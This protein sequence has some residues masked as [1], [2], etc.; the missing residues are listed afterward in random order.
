MS[1]VRTARRIAA[2]RIGTAG[3]I[4][5]L[6]AACGSTSASDGSHG[7]TA[8]APSLPLATA[9]A[10]PGQ[11]GWAIV[12]MG[13]SSKDFEN[14][15]EL[16]ARPAGSPTWKLATPPGVASNGGL[17]MAAS[18]PGLVTGFR[19]SQDLTFSPLAAIASP[20]ATWS[21]GSAPVSPGLA[22]VPDALASGPHGAMIALTSTGQ[23]QLAAPGTATLARLTTE[24]ELARTAAGRACGLTA[25]TAVGFAADGTPLLAGT[26]TRGGSAGLFAWEQG[27]AVAAGLPGQAGPTSV[28]GLETA[29]GRTTALL[30]SGSGKA[31]TVL[32]AW[33]A[34][35][36]ADWTSSP[37]VS[38]GAGNLRSQ[39]MWT[40]GGAALVLTGNKGEAI[41]G[42]GGSWQSLPALPAHTVTLALGPAGQLQALA[43]AGASLSV[44]QLAA[45][46]GGWSRIQ[47]IQVTVPYGSSS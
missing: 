14:F 5:V 8:P 47:Q 10:G 17:V 9:I 6:A 39:E 1:A 27:A 32:A 34:S 24:R 26:C 2:A 29:G 37:A 25:L 15:W 19:G 41:S 11:P 18:G 43:P 30:Q 31:A 46:D 3:A 40:N 4:A 33:S 23:V 35:G 45:G 22:S 7:T 21:Q 36:L 13:G 44:W 20:A 16:F 42:P 12:P 28:I 38:T